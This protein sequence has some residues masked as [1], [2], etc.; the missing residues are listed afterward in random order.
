[1]AQMDLRKLRMHVS[2]RSNMLAAVSKLVAIIWTFLSSQQTRADAAGNA[3]TNG[4][5][6]II[7]FGSQRELQAG[8]MLT[9]FVDVRAIF[10]HNFLHMFIFEPQRLP[11]V[12]TIVQIR[13]I[14]VAHATPYTVRLLIVAMHTDNGH[15]QQRP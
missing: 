6:L 13:R 5:Q 11:I 15:Q 12:W 8:W 14:I 4:H 3:K 1:M 7:A 9:I 10:H 2:H